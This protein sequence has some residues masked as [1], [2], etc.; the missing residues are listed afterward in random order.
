MLARNVEYSQD[1]QSS[2]AITQV[3]MP[4]YREEDRHENE[5]DVTAADHDDRCLCEV[6]GDLKNVDSQEVDVDVAVCKVKRGDMTRLG[7]LA[8]SS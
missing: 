6:S 4:P 2:E 7:S 1:D 3:G 8:A 5:D